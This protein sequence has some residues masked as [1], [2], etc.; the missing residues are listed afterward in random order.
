MTFGL[1]ATMVLVLLAG[2][3]VAGFWLIVL[4]SALSRKIARRS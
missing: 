4:T 1:G 3:I 2:I